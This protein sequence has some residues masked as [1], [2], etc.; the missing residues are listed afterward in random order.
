MRWEKHPGSVFSVNI[1]EPSK[2]FDIKLQMTLTCTQV[3]IAE[4][5]KLNLKKLTEVPFPDLLEGGYQKI[6]LH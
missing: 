5:T 6:D 1:L 3:L 4:L 2:G